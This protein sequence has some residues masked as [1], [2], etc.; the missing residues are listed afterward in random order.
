MRE[1][2][3]GIGFLAPA[4]IAVCLFFFLPVMLTVVFAFT[5]M[6]TSTG[7]TIGDYMISPRQLDQ[8]ETSGVS[9]ETIGR[10]ESAGFQITENGLV[11]LAAEFGDDRADELREDYMGESFTARRDLE[12]VLRN[13]NDN[14]IRRTRDRKLAADLLSVSIVGERFESEAEFR[15]ALAETGIQA[16]D[17]DVLTEHAYTGWTWTNDNFKRLVELPATVRYAFNTA[18]YVVFTL[19]FNITF[20]LFLAISTFYLPQRLASTFRS[21]WFLP[22]ILPPV[23]YVIMWKWFTWDTGFISIVLSWFGVA[24]QNWMLETTQHAWTVVVL[25]NGFVGAS[26]GM[27]LFSSAIKAIPTSMLYASEVDGAYRWHQVR[28]IIL[29]Q[30]RWPILFMTSYQT[31]SLLTSFEYILLATEGGPGGGTKTWALAAYM[32]ALRNYGGNLEYGFGAAYALV[33]VFIGII[34]SALYLRLFNFKEL[35]VKP[36]IEQ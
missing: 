5:N 35:V 19:M 7:I 4:L 12:R 18:I 23:M 36:R 8:I 11:A 22:R 28:Y 20:G 32:T 29:P 21:I 14:P 31:L 13:L 9:D 25:I 26:L 15:D 24:Q 34:L 27:I 2:L 10:L 1:R 17:H 33:L 6:S 30:M 16:S 3:L